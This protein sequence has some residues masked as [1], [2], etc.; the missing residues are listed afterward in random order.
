MAQSATVTSRTS[1]LTTLKRRIMNKNEIRSALT[2]AIIVD[3]S[4]FCLF[5]YVRDGRKERRRP[6]PHRTHFTT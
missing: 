4:H 2:R 1:T 5:S 6:V 3:Y